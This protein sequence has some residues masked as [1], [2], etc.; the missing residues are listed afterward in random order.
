MSVCPFDHPILGGLLG[1]EEIAGYFSVEAE[2]KAM[3][4][5]EAALATAQG[6]ARLISEETMSAI[7]DAIAAFEPDIDRLRMAVS[8]GRRC[9]AGTGAAVAR[10]DRG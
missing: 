10:S 2:I 4:V 9:R 3:L 8:T 6:K 7:V 5:F 1:D